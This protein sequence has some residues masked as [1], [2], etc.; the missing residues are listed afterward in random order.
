MLH[1]SSTN[2]KAY[3]QGDKGQFLKCTVEKL[4][5]QL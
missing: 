4:V 1:L 2:T 5:I 3:L